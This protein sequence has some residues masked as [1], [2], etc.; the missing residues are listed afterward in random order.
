MESIKTRDPA[1]LSK[2]CRENFTISEIILTMINS[3]TFRVKL[4]DLDVI[5]SDVDRLQFDSYDGVS[6]DN[7]KVDESMHQKLEILI[8][9]GW[10]T[11]KTYKVCAVSKLSSRFLMWCDYNI[12]SNVLN[13]CY[14]DM[15][16]EYY[17]D[18]EY[19]LPFMLAEFLRQVNNKHCKVTIKIILPQNRDS[20]VL[21]ILKFFEEFKDVFTKFRSFHFVIDIVFGINTD[22]TSCIDRLNT[23]IDLFKKYANTH[24]GMSCE[25]GEVYL[26]F[27]LGKKHPYNMNA[28]IDHICSTFDI[29]LITSLMFTGVCNKGEIDLTSIKK[30]AYVKSIFFSSYINIDFENLGDLRDMT[31]LKEMHFSHPKVH[32][33]WLSKYLPPSMETIKFT[34]FDDWLY[35]DY[36]VFYVPPNIKCIKYQNEG[37]AL[38][39]FERFDF[40]NA[41]NL[42]KI[43][44]SPHSEVNSFT[45]I[46]EITIT[47]MKKLPESVRY[48]VVDSN[49]PTNLLCPLD[50]VRIKG[51]D[52][53]GVYTN[54]GVKDEHLCVVEK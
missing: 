40:R 39:E 19:F 33:E 18:S 28:I 36:S 44:L 29:K 52:L 47:G 51:I 15:I 22:F 10:I 11:L 17:F 20:D 38:F 23:N 2:V 46:H 34:Q 6:F 32:F 43:C 41:D 54:I 9:D 42:T 5:V 16:T 7:F 45:K 4:E 1:L 48:F 25:I 53:S 8:R 37:E 12:Q 3:D 35:G 14:S 31:S 13:L 27:F 50:K 30:L 26:K 24:P 49:N 21:D